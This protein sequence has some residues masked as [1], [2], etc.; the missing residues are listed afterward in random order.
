MRK[1]ISESNA[2]NGENIADS[3]FLCEILRIARKSQNLVCF[4]HCE[5]HEAKRV[6]RSNPQ[7]FAIAKM[8]KLSQILRKTLQIVILSVAKN[9]KK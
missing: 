3:A 1:E 7:I 4:R 5:A 2:K 8:I 6:Q 9:L